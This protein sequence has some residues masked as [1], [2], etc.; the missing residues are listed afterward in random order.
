MSGADA[1]AKIQAGADLVQL[2][3]GLIYQGPSLVN[4]A[5]RAIH[6]HDGTMR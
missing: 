6:G 3:S 1:V 2:Y 5:A 4:A